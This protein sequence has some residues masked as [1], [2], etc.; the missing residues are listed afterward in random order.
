MRRMFL[1]FAILIASMCVTAGIASAGNRDFTFSVVPKINMLSSGSM[2]TENYS[3]TNNTNSDA[4]CDIYIEQLNFHI[5]LGTVFAGQNAG[6]QL[7]TPTTGK[8]TKLTFDLSCDGSHVASTTTVS[9]T[10]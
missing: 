6:G 7:T 1:I 8:V 10:K 4:T 2:I 9:I 3:V 5:P